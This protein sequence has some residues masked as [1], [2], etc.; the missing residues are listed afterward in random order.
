MLEPNMGAQAASASYNYYCDRSPHGSSPAGA[1]A[2]GTQAAEAAGA[3]EAAE[4]AGGNGGGNGILG[5]DDSY[6]GMVTGTSG[7]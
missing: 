3:P 2:G 1:Q 7:L 5:P 4:A 6:P